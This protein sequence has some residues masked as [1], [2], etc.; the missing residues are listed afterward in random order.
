MNDAERNTIHPS[1]SL[2]PII[3]EVR[4][5]GQKAE[6][7]AYQFVPME[8]GSLLEVRVLRGGDVVFTPVDQ[9]GDPEPLSEEALATIPPAPPVSVGASNGASQPVA[10]PEPEPEPEPERG[11][12][13]RFFGRK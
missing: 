11:A 8:D 4:E 5:I 1:P 12:W 3:A 9:H 7:Y 6:S 13:K 10:Q 2:N